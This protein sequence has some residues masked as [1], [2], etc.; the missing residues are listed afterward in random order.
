MAIFLE[1]NAIEGEMTEIKEIGRRTQY[2][3]QNR[4]RHWELKEEIEEDGNDSLS[5]EHMDQIQITFHKSKDMIISN[6]II[7][8]IIIIIIPTYLWALTVMNT[9]YI[10]S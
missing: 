3:L 9:T 2:D 10:H 5:L 7:I 4:R 1:E 6:I 8:I